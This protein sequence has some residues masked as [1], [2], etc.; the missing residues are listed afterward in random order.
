MNV[1][2]VAERSGDWWAVRVPQLPGVFTQ[3]RRLDQV[4]AMVADAVSAFL[5]IPSEDIKVEVQ[6][7]LA[8]ELTQRLE[9]AREE[10]RHA[11]QLASA[12]ADKLRQVARTLADEG[13]PE[14]DIGSIL[15]VSHQRAHQ[16]LAVRKAS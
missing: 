6:P 4:N 5:D 7:K 8:V 12:A 16:L 15:G 9:E 13:L 10:R 11:D 14:R 2:A 1:T 3:V